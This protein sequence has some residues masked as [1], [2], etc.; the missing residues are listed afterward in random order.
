M[1]AACVWG[2][3]AHWQMEVQKEEEEEGGWDSDSLGCPLS[4][5]D[6]DGR[7]ELGAAFRAAAFGDMSGAALQLRPGQGEAV[8]TVFSELKIDKEREE[9]SFA[10]E[11]GELDVH[12]KAQIVR[13]MAAGRDAQGNKFVNGYRKVCNLSKGNICS[14]KVYEHQGEKFAF[15]C[16]RRNVLG[17]TNRYLKSKTDP[18]K[19]DIET[20]FDCVQR[21]INILANLK[22]HENVCPLIQILDSE[23]WPKLYIV[24]PFFEQGPMMEFDSELRVFYSKSTSA[25]LPKD[26]AMRFAL[27]ISR[28]ISHLHEQK[29]VHRD[30]KPENVFLAKGGA[31]AVLSDFSCSHYFDESDNPHGLLDGTAGTYAF[32]SPEMCAGETFDAYQ[33]DVWAFGVTI[34][35]TFFGK[36]PFDAQGPKQLFDKI[37]NPDHA[38]QF[39]SSQE[40]AACPRLAQSETQVQETLQD[41][42]SLNFILHLLQHD[43]VERP[44]IRQVVALLVELN[45]NK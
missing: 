31:K 14:V 33:A 36:L 43:P 20:H 27:D 19:M 15:K 10:D 34:F 2:A 6:S 38:I 18:G 45:S 17:R 12:D 13:D 32:F 7:W 16:Y 42:N 8:A 35:A 41:Q 25:L 28:A 44:K 1:H 11:N 3:R 37:K 40:Y 30:I 9:K 4:P 22:P 26:A 21:E 24:L 29:I 5:R 39:P 23:S